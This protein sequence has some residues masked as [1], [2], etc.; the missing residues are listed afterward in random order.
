MSVNTK[1]TVSLSSC[2]IYLLRNTLAIR[3]R[4]IQSIPL[5][6]LALLPYLVLTHMHAFHSQPDKATALHLAAADGHSKCVQLL[7]QNGAS[8]D[9]QSIVRSV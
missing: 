1:T 9:S 5:Y 6:N 8:V 7:I 4:C 3:A 2:Y